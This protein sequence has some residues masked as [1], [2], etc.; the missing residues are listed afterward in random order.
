MFPFHTPPFLQPLNGLL[1]ASG[2]SSRLLW[3]IGRQ[4]LLTNSLSYHPAIP[5]R[6]FLISLPK[7]V[8]SLGIILFPWV[9]TAKP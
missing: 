7:R 8:S 1:L 5:S 9:T 3:H 4:V 2:P 6:D